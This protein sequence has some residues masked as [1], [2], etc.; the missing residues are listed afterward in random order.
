MICDIRT[1]DE[2]A[3]FAAGFADDPA[4]SDPMLRTGEQVSRNLAGAISRPEGHRVIGVYGGGALRGVFSFLVDKEAGYLELLAGLSRDK[5]AYEEM[6]DW[7]GR[8]FPGCGADF[9]FNPRNRPLRAALEERGAAFDPEELRLVWDRRPLPEAGGRQVVPYGAACREAYLA[10]H[11]DEGR[12]WTGEKVLAAQDRFRV[13]LALHEGRVAGYID[14]TCPFAENE[15]YDLFVC[16]EARG[17]GYGKA[18]LRAALAANGPRGMA[19]LVEA[20]NV[21]AVR[22]FRSL[23]FTED[24]TGSS[25]LAR[26]TL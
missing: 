21:P 6:L 10:L 1:I 3:G 9:V 12:Y 4:F 19:A 22:L 8:Q 25:V 23:G 7:L 17:R 13:F 5:G 2:I 16:E 14:V 18:L 11:R 24:P 20:E 15:P 26:L